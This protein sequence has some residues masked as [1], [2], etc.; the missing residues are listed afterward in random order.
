LA[1][2]YGFAPS[3]F[4]GVRGHPLPVRQAGATLVDENILLT[5]DAAGL[6]DP[7]SGEGIFAAIWSGRAAAQHLA[8][9]LSGETESLL[10]YAEDVERVLGTDL[11][12]ARQLH[13]LFHAAPTLWARFVERSPRA[14]HLICGLV[15]GDA[16]YSG[17]R[18]TSRLVSLGLVLGVQ[19]LH[20]ATHLGRRELIRSAYQSL[21]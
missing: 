21:G 5:G 7:L 19:G 13:A 16:T 8:R 3:A 15:T 14:W 6:L 4:W 12:V 9:Y 18:D 10:G 1:R 20:L 11:C 17:A 2:Y